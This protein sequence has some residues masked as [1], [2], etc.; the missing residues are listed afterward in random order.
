M[1]SIARS[2]LVIALGLALTACSAIPVSTMIKMAGFGV[3]DLARIDPA[4]LRVR[5]SVSEGFELDAEN[6]SL[7]LTISRADG[8]SRT[9]PLSLE[10]VE[11]SRMP[12]SDGLLSASRPLPTQVLRLTPQGAQEL[13]AL[14]EQMLKR[15]K[16]V[17]DTV[18]FKV[19]F[20]FSKRPP[21]PRSVDV[22]V[23][24]KFAATEDW[25]ALIDAATLQF[26]ARAGS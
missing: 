4:Q 14:R 16:G 1:R 3:E 17:K 8:P 20:G 23:D 11:R 24:L 15:P 21:D 12:R 25:L 18:S 26:K 10:L 9:F 2:L 19:D 5:M 6:A 7:N 22:W 13:V